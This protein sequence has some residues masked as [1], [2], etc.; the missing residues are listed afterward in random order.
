MK[1]YRDLEFGDYRMLN[2][3]KN[4][5]FWVKF[6]FVGIALNFAPLG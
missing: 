6:Y 1:I 2:D 4:G 3:T 5:Q